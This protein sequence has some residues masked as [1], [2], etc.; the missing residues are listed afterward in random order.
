MQ[1]PDRN[2]SGHF[3][4]MRNHKLEFGTLAS[5]AVLLYSSTA[6]KVRG[7]SIRS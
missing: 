7:M 1:C 5:I 4:S 6:T 2:R 3:G